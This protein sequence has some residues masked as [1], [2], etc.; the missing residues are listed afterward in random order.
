MH[1]HHEV[2]LWSSGS[3]RSEERYCLAENHHGPTEKE[4]KAAIYNH[5]FFF[6]IILQ[7]QYNF[8]FWHVQW[9]CNANRE[10]HAV[11]RCLKLTDSW[12]TSSTSCLMTLAGG[13]KMEALC[14]DSQASRMEL[15]FTLR[16]ARSSHMVR[17]RLFRW[18][19]NWT[20]WQGEWKTIIKSGG[21]GLWHWDRVAVLFQGLPPDFEVGENQLT[22]RE[23]FPVNTPASVSQ[24]E[25]VMDNL[26]ILQEQF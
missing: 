5:L 14:W 19:L 15:R 21:V 17:R 25:L 26:R 23:S 6:S 8:N 4:D 18:S 7:V 11:D 12:K 22:S 9:S 10:R 16:W 3:C 1:T 13:S 24:N 2:S 20:G